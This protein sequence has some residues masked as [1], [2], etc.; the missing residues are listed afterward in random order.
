M[1]I[2][3]GQISAS[4]ALTETKSSLD[5]KVNLTAEKV[6]AEALNKFLVIPENY[7][8]GEIE[9]LAL[10]GTGTIDCAPHLE[11]HAV[12]ADERCASCRQSISIA[13]L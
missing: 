7:L 9:R 8:S 10:D 13:A 12:A 3:G 1:P 4:A 5:T 2:G 6:A 11:R